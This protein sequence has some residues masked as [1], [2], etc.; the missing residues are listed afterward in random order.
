MSQDTGE[1]SCRHFFHVFVRRHT[2]RSSL[3]LV[4]KHNKSDTATKPTGVFFF[5]T[6]ESNEIKKDLCINFGHMH[7]PTRGTNA[8]LSVRLLSY[9][10]CARTATRDA[11]NTHMARV[12]IASQVIIIKFLTNVGAVAP[13]FLL[14]RRRTSAGIEQ[15]ETTT[16]RNPLPPPPARPL[17]PLRILS[18]K[19]PNETIVSKSSLSFFFTHQ[20]TTELR[21]RKKKRAHTHTQYHL[22]SLIPLTLLLQ[23]DRVHLSVSV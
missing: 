1:A 12:A 4:T 7:G 14:P 9:S 8:L 22:L 13:P 18:L 3:V 15:P 17:S 10:V 23:A 19:K 5:R 11:R 16:T 20:S 2:R 6:I 21:K